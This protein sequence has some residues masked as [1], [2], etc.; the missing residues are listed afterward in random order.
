MAPPT[1]EIVGYSW[2]CP[3]GVRPP[4]GSDPNHQMN[5]ERHRSPRSVAPKG[6]AL[7]CAGGSSPPS[8]CHPPKP[9]SSQPPPV[10]RALARRTMPRIAHGFNRGRGRSLA[11]PHPRSVQ[12]GRGPGEGSLVWDRPRIT[13]TPLAGHGSAT[14][15]RETMTQADRVDRAIVSRLTYPRN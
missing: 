4:D 8:G 5:S 2:S 10:R 6:F 15:I 14:T 12:G 1:I 7:P 11:A 9:R 13:V 3:P